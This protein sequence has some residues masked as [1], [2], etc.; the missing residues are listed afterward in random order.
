MG[1][2]KKYYVVWEGN[3]PG[4][5]DNWTECQLQI[6]GYPGAKY[7]SFKSKEEAENAYGDNY[8]E[9][10]KSGNKEA[11]KA[12]AWDESVIIKNSISV[13]AAC[14]GNPGLMEYRGVDTY[15]QVEHFRQGP[16]AHGTNNVGEFLAIIHGLAWLTY[17]QRY[18]VVTPIEGLLVLIPIFVYPFDGNLLLSR[19]LTTYVRYTQAAFFI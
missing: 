17:R 18:K 12:V 1:K 19:Y 6:K 2:S 9:H 3:T 13:D 7:K 15:T 5:Y 16:F 11:K 4:I 14:S 10:Y 8:Q